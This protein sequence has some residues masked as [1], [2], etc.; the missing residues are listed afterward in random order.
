MFLQEVYRSWTYFLRRWFTSTYEFDWVI[1]KTGNVY[2]LARFNITENCG[3][4]G[5]NT[6][7]FYRAQNSNQIMVF[8]MRWLNLNKV[9]RLISFALILFCLV[10]WQIKSEVSIPGVHFQW[11]GYKRLE[12]IKSGLG[13]PMYSQSFVQTV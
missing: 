12:S 1:D 13:D 10:G 11:E 4:F 6:G 8:V 7:S 5:E 3:R 2:T 9:G